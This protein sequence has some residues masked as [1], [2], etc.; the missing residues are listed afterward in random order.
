MS[1]NILKAF[2]D[3][4]PA[5]DFILPGLLAGTVGAL[6]APGSTGKS[7]FALQL[8]IDAAGGDLL[9]IFDENRN[10]DELQP[11]LYIALEDPS[12]VLINRLHSIGQH[13]SKDA[14]TTVAGRLKLESLLGRRIDLMNDDWLRWLIESAQAM[15]ARLIVIDTLNRAH[16]GDENS[17]RDM[18]LLLSHLEAAAKLTGCGIL[19]LHHVAKGADLSGQSAARGA[20][21]LIDN[22]RFAGYIRRMTREEAELWSE[23]PDRVSIAESTRSPRSVGGVMG[24]DRANFVCFGSSKINYGKEGD[25]R[26]F[27]RHAGGVL[28]PVKLFPA[29]EDKKS[30]TTEAGGRRG[31][32]IA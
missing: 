2:A 31:R 16:Q 29:S 21:A 27:R 15:K 14:W 24:A 6:V 7:F 9:N 28:L 3:E 11:V 20:S 4:P 5:L 8:A 12:E 10:L 32:L 1:I 22:A 26:W 18:S 25:G 23:F 13:L 19:Y 30:S 17:N